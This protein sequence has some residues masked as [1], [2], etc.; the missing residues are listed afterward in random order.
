MASLAAAQIRVHEFDSDAEQVL[1]TGPDWS[2]RRAVKQ[3]GQPA[4][5]TATKT[6]TKPLIS[7]VNLSPAPLNS[8]ARY[9]K[10][11]LAANPCGAKESPPQYIEELGHRLA[12]LLMLWQKSRRLTAAVKT[13]R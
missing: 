12:E 1:F 2:Y 11:P 8:P 5:E 13:S 3:P 7:A 6:T 4:S 10:E 9:A